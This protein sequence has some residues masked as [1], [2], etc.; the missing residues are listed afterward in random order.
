MF[1]VTLLLV[2]LAV[3][4]SVL[5]PFSPETFLQLRLPRLLLGLCAG[6]VLSVSGLVFQCTFRQDLASPYTFGVASAASAGAAMGVFLGVELIWLSA[7]GMTLISVASISLMERKFRLSS[8][9]LILGGVINSFIFS[10]FIIVFHYVTGFKQSGN[11]VRWLMGS[12]EVVGY[13]FTLITVPAVCLCLSGAFYYRRELNCFA[14]DETTAES[15]GVDTSKVRSILL[16]LQSVSVCLI[17]SVTGPIGF[18][19]LV[20]PHLVKRVTKFGF[21]KR[22][23]LSFLFGGCL[24]VIFDSLARY[25]FWPVEL[26]VGVVSSLIGGSIFLVILFRRENKKQIL[27]L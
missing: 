2:L 10:S 9:S 21:S 20:T 8:S 13:T 15:F 23:A 18:I 6:G 3:A 14:V 12:L 5:L 7:L 26:P 22:C 16:F 27:A 17:V 19:G 25:A 4:C 1:R 24:L 11:I